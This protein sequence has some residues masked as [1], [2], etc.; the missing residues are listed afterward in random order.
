MGHLCLKME[1]HNSGSSRRTSVEILLNIKDQEV[2]ENYFNGFPKH[3][4]L[5]KWAILDPK[6]V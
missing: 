2:H 5:G 3:F 6:M 4:I 1:R